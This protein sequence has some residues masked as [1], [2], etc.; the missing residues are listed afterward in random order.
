MSGASGGIGAD[1][2][3]ATLD[4]ACVVAEKVEDAGKVIALELHHGLRGISSAL[5]D[6]L[7][8]FGPDE[9]PNDNVVSG[10]YAIASALRDLVRAVEGAS[11]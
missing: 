8:C 1:T 9:A 4:A 6:G 10:L 11:K 7:G 2:F 5:A 3:D